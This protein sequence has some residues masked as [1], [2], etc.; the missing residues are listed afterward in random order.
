MNMEN[1]AY[2]QGGEMELKQR[3]VNNGV[4]SPHVEVE[5]KGIKLKRELGLISGTSIIV[6]TI[7]GSGI[8]ISPKGVLQE[9]G[10][11]GLSLVV[12][13]AGGLLSLMGALSYAELG[14]LI[15]KS[16][17]EYPYMMEAMGRV[18][19]YLFAW[20]KIIVLTPSSMAIICLTFAEYFMSLFDFCGEPQIPKKI[21]AALA[22]ITLAVVNSWDTKLAASVQVFFTGAKLIA[23]VIIVIGGLVWLG[24]GEVETI[25][26]GFEG[27]T[28]SP[29]SVALAFYDALWA[30]DGWNNLNYITEE[31]QNPYVNLPRANTVGVLLVTVIYILANISYLAVLGTDRLLNSSAVALDWGE[32]VLGKDLSVIMPIFV[33]FSTF[34]AANGS[35]FAGVRTL[36]VAARENQFP[37]VLSYVNARRLTPTPCIIFTTVVALLMLIPG[38]IGSLIDFFS[39]AAWMFYALAIVSLMILRFTRK[40]DYRPIKIFILFPIIFLLCSLYLVVAPIIQDPR[41]EFLYAFLFIIG[42]LLLYIPFVHF[43]IDRGCFDPITMFFQLF[44]EVGPSPYVP[45]FD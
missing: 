16:G 12:W 43:K 37:E 33:M 5:V 13:G 4:D 2:S 17:A 29:S 19:A 15:T 18:V 35:L 1:Q 38:D 3:P 6:G 31:L 9:T 41:V 24:K 21:V 26:K 11:V 32:I 30:Y 28:N 45:D 25:Q 39:F 44:L 20:T 34:G 27:T 7:I 23:L 22:M 42:G 14:T 10:S 40:D 8:F 36:Y